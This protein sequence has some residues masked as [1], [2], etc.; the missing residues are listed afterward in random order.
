MIEFQIK[1]KENDKLVI[2]APKFYCKL[3]SVELVGN[4]QKFIVDHFE[5]PQHLFRLLVRTKLNSRRMVQ[6]T[7]LFFKKLKQPDIFSKLQKITNND[8]LLNQLDKINFKEI[9][10]A[11]QCG[12]PILVRLSNLDDL[13]K[14]CKGNFVKILEYTFH[15]FLRL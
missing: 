6:L 11:L 15:S 13:Y 3:C 8:L 7:L 2:K 14:K 4:F 12:S 5:S 1:Q 10:S 9:F